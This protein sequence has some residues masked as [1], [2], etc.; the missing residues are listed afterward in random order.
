MKKSQLAYLTVFSCVLVLLF[1][2]NVMAQYGGSKEVESSMPF[3]TD[4]TDRTMLKEIL[5][6]QGKTLALLSEIKSMLQ[7]KK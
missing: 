2:L 7:E 1:S 6:N 5:V 3:A 4:K